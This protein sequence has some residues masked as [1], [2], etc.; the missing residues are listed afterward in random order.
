M[1]KITYTLYEFNDLRPK[2]QEKLIGQKRIDA[3][4]DWMLFDIMQ[5]D[6][7]EL[8]EEKGWKNINSDLKIYYSLS[9][10]QGDGFQFNGTFEKDDALIT[11]KQSGHYYHSY[12]T[13]INITDA[14]GEEVER[15]DL[16]QEYHEICKKLEDMG[17]TTI[18]DLTSDEYLRESLESEGN[19]YFE[20]G[21]IAPQTN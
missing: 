18:E 19:L 2:I 3:D 9:Y 12:C 1:Q 5:E 15:E 6:T 4:Y 17:Y 20:D 10:C 16:I 13:D 8:L 7:N 21:T 11:I 14:D